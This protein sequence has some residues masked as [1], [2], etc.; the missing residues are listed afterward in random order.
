MLPLIEVELVLIT[1][2]T[3]I[4]SHSVQFPFLCHMFRALYE[5]IVKQ[6]V[7]ELNVAVNCVNCCFYTT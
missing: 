1:L 2:Y 3:G 4:E 5:N 6:S 7:K